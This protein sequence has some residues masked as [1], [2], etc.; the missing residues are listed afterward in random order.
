MSRIDQAL[1]RAD[2][3]AGIHKPSR[4]SDE[5]AA[6]VESTL[7]QYPPEAGVPAAEPAVVSTARRTSSGVTRPP[8]A[9]SREEPARLLPHVSDWRAVA[10]KLVIA[11]DASAV[12]VE[13]YRHLAAGLYHAQTETGLKTI[14]VS[15]TLPREGKTLTVANL[16]LTLSESYGQR[17]LI[18]DADLRNPSMHR[19]FELSN[20]IGLSDYLRESVPQAPIIRVSPTLSVL[21]A[22]GDKTN[23]IAGLVSDRMKAFMETAASQFDWILLDTP[24]IGLLPDANL[25][26]RLADGV[27]FVVAASSSPCALV[28]RA[29]T[30]V[31]ADRVI[32]VVLNGA[33]ASM[34]PSN[35]QY[36]VYA[37]A[38]AHSVAQDHG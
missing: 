2:L 36:S 30:A 24:P 15:S 26:A 1:T 3:I 11:E 28:Q 8:A 33:A 19:L 23:P 21:P 31:G 4:G 32:G 20:E 17:V 29:L 35:A 27:V 14:M 13:Q 5:Q 38:G 10:G 9:P 25:L 34:L 22:G 6:T 16:A 37:P 12:W 7:D 18:V